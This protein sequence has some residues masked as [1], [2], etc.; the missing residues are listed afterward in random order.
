MYSACSQKMT[1]AGIDAVLDPSEWKFILDVGGDETVTVTD[2][3][4]DS[5]ALAEERALSEFLKNGYKL[6]EVSFKTYRTDIRKNDAITV[7]GVVYLVKSKSTAVDAVKLV[8]TI[9]AVRY[10]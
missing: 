6:R 3:L 10:E 9:K 7:R 4:L 1:R 2:P 5:E 8:T